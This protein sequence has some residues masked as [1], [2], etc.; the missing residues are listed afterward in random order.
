M[1]KIKHGFT[2]LAAKE[3]ETMLVREVTVTATPEAAMALPNLSS[4]LLLPLPSARSSYALVITKMSSTPRPAR[5][6]G[7]VAW[8]WLT[9]KPNADPKLKAPRID[10]RTPSMPAPAKYILK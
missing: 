8:S 4:A 2:V 7:M 5:K 10:A 9:A 6:N 3:N 1:Q